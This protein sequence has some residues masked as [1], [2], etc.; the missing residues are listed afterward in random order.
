[1]C[2]ARRNTHTHIQYYTLDKPIGV[3]VM[4]FGAI[5]MNTNKRWKN[6]FLHF[7]F[8]FIRL[9]KIKVY[10]I[11]LIIDNTSANACA[12][13]HTYT[14][15]QPQTIEYRLAKTTDLFTVLHK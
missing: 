4:Q 8:L 14:H 15:I 13:L 7:F 1:M 9:N 12:H 3:I 2:K 11:Q 10:N 6:R 5:G